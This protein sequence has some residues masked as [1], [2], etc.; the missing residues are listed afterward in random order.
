MKLLRILVMVVAVVALSGVAQ[1]RAQSDLSVT[2]D[3]MDY[4]NHPSMSVTA[5]VRDE[6]GVPVRGLSAGEFVIVEDMG[7]SFPPSELEARFNPDAAISIMLTIDLSG[8]MQ[9]RHIEEAMRVANEL[10]DRLNEQD[11]V[12]VIAFAD[13]VDVDPARL[14]DGKELDF[15][16]DKN[17]ARN[18][19]N[20][21]GSRIDPDADTPLYDAIF[22]SADLTAREPIGK[23]AIIVLTD[24]REDGNK[25]EGTGSLLTG[26]D[27]IDRAKDTAIPVFTVGLGS[28]IDSRYL[29]RLALTTGGEY[30]EDPDSDQLSAFFEDV[31][32]TLKQEY[33]LRFESTL[34][35]DDAPHSMVIRV[36]RPSGESGFGER[37]FIF[38]GAPSATI[39]PPTVRPTVVVQATTTE[40]PEPTAVAQITATAE[41]EPKSEGLIQ[42]LRDKAEEMM[43]DNPILLVGIGVGL[44]IL[45]G[46]I[47][48]LV[49]VLVRGR[50][51]PA[52]EFQDVG[53]EESFSPGADW[54]TESPQADPT[55]MHTPLTEA[56]SGGRTEAAPPG[57]GQMDAGPAPFQ[58]PPF[59][60]P[61]PAP[62]AGGFPADS[63]I[64]MAGET[65]MIQ[66]RSRH[67]GV[68]VNKLDPD[69][70][71]RI[72]GT[73]NVGRSQDNELV[74]AHPTVS[75]QHAW[76]RDED[77]SWIVFD[78]GSANGT[79]V[80]GQRITQPHSLND[81]DT[82]SFGQAEF[83]FEVL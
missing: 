13:T 7:S 47:I 49:V 6:Q 45:V 63:E 42:D 68:L 2:I 25:A 38:E 73:M 76:I 53:F 46:L 33:V 11:R 18:V 17:A 65:M 30:Q 40:E 59:E 14:A 83:R 9:G 70:A 77:D 32:D 79:S 57:W 28:D 55:P 23:R 66:G 31:L 82:V 27:A 74:V 5:T 12:A 10:V 48:A 61:S 67:I 1:V 43:E 26:I 37:T 64:P 71:H 19:I 78:I 21:L 20:F 56:P 80:N 51:K 52:E 75:R 3:E 72:S 4:Q 58:Q 36:A 41:P 34:P 69:Q 44:L 50:R 81:G 16:T 39:V 60:A 24:G 8:S 62:A 35:Y 22:K 15:T 29:Q 54:E